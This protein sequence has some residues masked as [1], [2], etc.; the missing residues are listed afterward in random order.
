MLRVLFYLKS[1]IQICYKIICFSQF[2]EKKKHYPTP[3]WHILK[4]ICSLHNNIY[5]KK[6]RFVMIYFTVPL[7]LLNNFWIFWWFIAC[8]W[9]IIFALFSILNEW[10]RKVE[11]PTSTYLR[12]IWENCPPGDARTHFDN[13]TRHRQKSGCR[14]CRTHLWQ[15]KHATAA[16]RVDASP[17]ARL[18][19]FNHAVR[20]HIKCSKL[21][22]NCLARTSGISQNGWHIALL[23][24]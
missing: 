9:Q 6:T 8:W 13:F 21:F 24:V 11:I 14:W 3:Q 1:E 4:E 10:A 19:L 15:S 22:P 17:A 23:A 5:T 16:A 18:V 12:W 7:K 20:V 2:L